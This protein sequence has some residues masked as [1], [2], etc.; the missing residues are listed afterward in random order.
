MP[1]WVRYLLF[2]VV[3]GGVSFGMNYYVWRRMVHDPG[4]PV[5]ARRIATIAMIAM[6]VFMIAA[7]V[8]R[9]TLGIG[10]TL[11]WIAYL[12]MG[13]IIVALFVWAAI[14]LGR[15]VVKLVELIAG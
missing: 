7:L 3:I 11:Q 5:Q 8:A 2:F 1:N 4:W 6:G 14:D 13:I 10:E 12:W 15:G 9:R